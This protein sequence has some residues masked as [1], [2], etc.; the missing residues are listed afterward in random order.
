MAPKAT[1]GVCTKQHSYSSNFQELLNLS[2]TE[3]RCYKVAGCCQ[4]P[5]LMR[6]IRT[7]RLAYKDK[8]ICPAESGR[9]WLSRDWRCW[10]LEWKDNSFQWKARYIHGCLFLSF[11]LCLCLC[12][13]VP[14]HLPVFISHQFT[15][16]GLP[17]LHVLALLFICLCC[18]MYE[19]ALDINIITP[20]PPSPTQ[21][22]RELLQSPE[23]EV[24]HLTEEQQQ[25][26]SYCPYT[27]VI[28]V[29]L[30]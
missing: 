9:I 21:H 13:H 5:L 17:V 30:I 25:Q 23:S 6:N 3:L 2:V 16:T 22:R 15:C 8:L 19:P 24:E 14:V 26:S 20:S 12:L 1:K 27:K 28:A 18:G 10:P 7:A 11:H 4:Y 29:A